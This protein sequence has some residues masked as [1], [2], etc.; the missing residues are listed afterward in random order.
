MHCW[1]VL[2][3]ALIVERLLHVFPIVITAVVAIMMMMMLKRKMPALV[4]R[5]VSEFVAPEQMIMTTMA[6]VVR[7]GHVMLMEPT[8]MRLGRGQQRRARVFQ[9]REEMG[10]VTLA[11]PKYQVCFGYIVIVL[12]SL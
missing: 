11:A 1:S 8:K 6:R 5:E 7:V 2:A 9:E 12:Y 10:E 4:E 3:E